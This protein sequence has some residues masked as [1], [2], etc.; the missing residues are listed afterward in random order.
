MTK[1][2]PVVTESCNILTNSMFMLNNIDPPATSTAEMG[3]EPSWT[4]RC[5]PSTL[6]DDLQKQP[7]LSSISSLTTTP[8]P[9]ASGFPPAYPYPWAPMQSYSYPTQHS[10]QTA[11]SAPLSMAEPGSLPTAFPVADRYLNDSSLQYSPLSSPGSCND[12]SSYQDQQLL[13]EP[14]HGRAPCPSTSSVVLGVN[15]SHSPLVSHVYGAMTQSGDMISTVPSFEY[16]MNHTPISE[17]GQV[18]ERNLGSGQKAVK[19]PQSKSTTKSNFLCSNIS[20]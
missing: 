13:E 6:T 12:G 9:E 11:C 7:P 19:M 5:P 16:L 14:F 1:N 20:N 3:L 4:I 17:L 8:P 2:E 10:S 15:R 18:G